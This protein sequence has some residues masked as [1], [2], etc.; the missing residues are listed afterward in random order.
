MKILLFIFLISAAGLKAEGQQSPP[1]NPKLSKEWQEA[2]FKGHLKEYRAFVTSKA[3]YAPERNGWELTGYI[4]DTP[5]I[6]SCPFYSTIDAKGGEGNL[7]V[8]QFEDIKT[9]ELA[10]KKLKSATQKI[11]QVV[12][13]DRNCLAH[14]AD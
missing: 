11:P 3:T 5:N 8:F 2:L 14:I 9:C 13:I 6:I 4:G 10:V 7:R 12:V 1:H